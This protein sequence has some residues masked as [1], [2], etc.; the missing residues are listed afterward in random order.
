MAWSP[1]TFAISPLTTACMRSCSIRRAA[2][3]A[4]CTPTT[5]ASR[6]LSKP[7][8]AKLE[9]ILATFDHYII[10][11]DVE[12]T[13]ISENQTALGMTGP[14]ARA[15]L[16]IAGIEVPNL[17]PLQMITPQCNCDC[18]CVQCTV[19]RGEDAPQESYEIWLTPQEVYEA[20]GG[21]DRGRRHARGHPKRWNCIASSLAFRSTALIFASATCRRKLS[22]RGP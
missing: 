2:F 9:K 18:G 8:A 14:K 10:M 13:N 3:S 12:V 16:K 5:R 11:D 17:L 1:T 19:I 22:R 7:I 20:L 4:T 21:V 15:I 6:S